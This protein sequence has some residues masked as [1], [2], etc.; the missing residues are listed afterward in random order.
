MQ[1][2]TVEAE[3]KF[4]IQKTEENCQ[5]RLQEI[6]SNLR[7]AE[8]Q[9]HFQTRTLADVDRERNRLL[10][11]LQKET[12][13]ENSTL[14]RI[15]MSQKTPI[16]IS[17]EN[18]VSRSDSLTPYEI[19][20]AND[21]LCTLTEHFREV[22][23]RSYSKLLKW[24]HDSRRTS[25]GTTTTTSAEAMKNR[26]CR[27]LCEFVRDVIYNE[28][29][30]F[31]ISSPVKIVLK[32]LSI[33]QKCIA[34]SNVQPQ[35]KPTHTRIKIEGS[36]QSAIR[37]R[38]AVKDLQ[39]S[40]VRTDEDTSCMP[41]VLKSLRTLLIYA[42]QDHEKDTEMKRIRLDLSISFVNVCYECLSSC[43]TREKED[44]MCV[45]NEQ[46]KFWSSESNKSMKGH[47]VLKYRA[48]GFVRERL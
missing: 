29:E 43:I 19:L 44:A 1:L 26:L 48:V 7:R 8:S 23:S 21:A 13:S 22:S 35:S 11:R 32:V 45:L 38:Q 28:K 15:P 18:S 16:S 17:Q 24:I 36:S 27:I 9:L 3:K 14:N 5:K 42:S 25:T 2:Q 20:N 34:L 33:L 6:E 12:I 30:E 4:E 40:D 47:Y 46:L 10:K 41:F 39:H 37:L 31:Q